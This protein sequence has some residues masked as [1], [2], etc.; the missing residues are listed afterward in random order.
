LLRTPTGFAMAPMHEGKVVKPEVFNA[1]P[2]AMRRDVEGK[3]GALEKELAVILER[4]PAAEKR[5]RQQLSEL[6]EEIATAAI[7]DA[8]VNLHASFNDVTEAAAF[9]EAAAH[10]MVRNVGLFLATGEEENAIVKRPTD[11][12]QDPRFRRYLVN[13][14]SANGES[15]AGAPIVEE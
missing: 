8:I 4:L 9:L 5:R 2:E 14:M 1:L 10:D 13:I 15:P 3:I 7:R 6:N 12:A 11:S